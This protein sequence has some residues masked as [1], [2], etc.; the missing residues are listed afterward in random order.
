[1]KEDIKGIEK[2]L[3]DV[4]GVKYGVKIHRVCW[5]LVDLN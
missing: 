3:R 4:F 2:E 1:M 5:V